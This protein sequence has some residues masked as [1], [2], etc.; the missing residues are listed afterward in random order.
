M[1]ALTI[2]AQDPWEMCGHI[3]RSENRIILTR[4]KRQGRLADFVPTGC[5]YAVRADRPLDQVTELFSHFRVS[6]DSK[7]YLFSRCMKCN[8]TDFKSLTREE[9]K[10]L[11]KSASNTTSTYNVEA[12]PMGVI[13][14]EKNCIFYGCVCG[15]IY[16]EGSH[17]TRALEEG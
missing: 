7:K 10:H 6:D 12:V 5:C 8:S 4:A 16:W 3:G 11:K 2:T 14:N 17:W 13:D 15:Q 1:D 9:L